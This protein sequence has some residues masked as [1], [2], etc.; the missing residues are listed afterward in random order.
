[1]TLNRFWKRTAE[2]VENEVVVKGNYHAVARLDELDRYG[3][4]KM[5]PLCSFADDLIFKHSHVLEI[6]L[7]PNSQTLRFCS[8]C[9]NYLLRYWEQF[10]NK[11]TSL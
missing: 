6:E 7:G 11:V 1:M 10:K 9:T 8:D 4:Q 2:S 3:V 5:V